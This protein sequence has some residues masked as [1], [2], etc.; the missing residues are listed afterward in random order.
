MKKLLFVILFLIPFLCDAQIHL[1]LR[2]SELQELYPEDKFIIE[3]NDSGTK[4]TSFEG[5]FGTYVY[6]FDKETHQINYMIKIMENVGG[7]NAQVEVFNK[8]YVII[9]DTS[10]RAYL[11]E[12]KII[13]IK[14]LYNKELKASYF[15]YVE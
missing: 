14:L 7:L 4:Y 13:K 5:D 15:E 3:L 1:G 12:G 9:S 10:W 8:Q 11:E 2:L 6:Y